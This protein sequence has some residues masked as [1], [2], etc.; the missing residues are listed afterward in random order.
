MVSSAT[1]ASH[2][3][4]RRGQLA[5]VATFALSSSMT[6]RARGWSSCNTTTRE[7]RDS[8]HS[9]PGSSENGTAKYSRSISTS[10]VGASASSAAKSTLLLLIAVL[11]RLRRY[12]SCVRGAV[13]A[14]IIGKSGS[15][16]LPM[17]PFPPAAMRL[18]WK[19][20]KPTPEYSR[21]SS[22]ASTL[23]HAYAGCS[24]AEYLVPLHSGS[25]SARRPCPSDLEPPKITMRPRGAGRS[26]NGRRRP[27]SGS[28]RPR[29]VRPP[30]LASVRTTRW[31]VDV[32]L[33]SRPLIWWSAWCSGVLVNCSRLQRGEPSNVPAKAPSTRT[34]T[35]SPGAPHVVLSEGAFSPRSKLCQSQQKIASRPLRPRVAQRR[36]AATKT[37]SVPLTWKP[38][39]APG[40][41]SERTPPASSSTHRPCRLKKALSLEAATNSPRPCAMI[42]GDFEALHSHVF[43]EASA[44]AT[45]RRCSER[46]WSVRNRLVRSRGW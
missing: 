40:D 4:F 6:S 46:G 25:A 26:G 8:S 14:F 32:A 37:L 12:H 2:S 13:D 39:V 36:C 19:L 27:P 9:F 29:T 42:S 43:S 3:D 11:A 38:T 41:Q 7:A 34:S 30:R 15:K 44:A 45:T 5:A 1:I 16:E 23:G 20:P 31:M 17:T 33:G 24:T 35:S 10:S 28:T 18:Q 22:C 21:R